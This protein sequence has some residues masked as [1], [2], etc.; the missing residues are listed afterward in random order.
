MVNF[1]R[2]VT[3]QINF[4]IKELSIFSVYYEA[5]F[6]YWKDIASD[7]ENVVL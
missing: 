7:E 5:E 6:F 1:Y 3:Q 4:F 2:A